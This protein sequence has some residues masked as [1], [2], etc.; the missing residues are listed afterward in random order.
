MSTDSRNRSV[1]RR[2]TACAADSTGSVNLLLAERIR[3]TGSMYKPAPS[4]LDGRLPACP[5]RAPP[6]SPGQDDFAA[7]QIIRSG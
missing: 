7:R 6:G 5:A 2:T 3:S 4:T 1:A